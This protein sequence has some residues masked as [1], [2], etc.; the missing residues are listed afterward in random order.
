MSFPLQT[1]ESKYILKQVIGKGAQS[2]VYWG[3]VKS[4]ESLVAIK[5]FHESKMND[6][7]ADHEVSILKTLSAPGHYNIMKIQEA[8]IDNN[9]RYLVTEYYN[10]MN[11]KRAAKKL[12]LLNSISDYQF[13]LLDLL[14]D[15]LSALAYIHGH[16]IVHSDIKYTNIQVV[17][18]YNL[19]RPILIDFGLSF[20]QGSYHHNNI[21]GTPKYIAPELWQ[22]FRNKIDRADIAKHVTT[23]VDIWALGICF[24]GLVYD[25][26][27]WPKELHKNFSKLSAYI[28]GQKQLFIKSS[29]N[30]RLNLL[31]SHML[32]Y[33]P[34]KRWSAQRLLEI[35]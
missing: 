21:V 29:K 8:F 1:L 12:H 4:D 22:C 33:D 35:Q 19:L 24:Y 31:L 34:N 27:V 28:T 25:T 7:V 17:N 26:E 11:L 6:R 32:Q 9:T 23:N 10:G 2:L 30:K 13:Y 16:G 15:L 3:L 18:E 20:K 5:Q 14:R